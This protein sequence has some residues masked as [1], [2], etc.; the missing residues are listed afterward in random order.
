MKNKDDA[1]TPFSVIADF[2]GDIQALLNI[3]PGTLLPLLPVR[4][5][6]LFPSSLVPIA[7]ERDFSK[8]VVGQAQKDDRFI[9]LVYQKDS[10]VEHPSLDDLYPLGTIAR[11]MRILPGA[12]GRQTVFLQ[13]FNR[14]RLSGLMRQK[15]YYVGRIEQLKEI[16]PPADSQEFQAIAD[17]C[18][19]RIKKLLSLTQ[20]RES[21]AMFDTIQNPVF[22]INFICT[23]LPVDISERMELL[24]ESDVQLRALHLCELLGRELQYAEL[25]QKIEEEA[26]ADISEQQKEYF[27]RQQIFRMQEE[28][29]E[30]ALDDCDEL[31]QRAAEAQLPELQQKTFQKEVQKLRRLNPQSPDYNVQL[32]Y[33]QTIV[34]LPWARSTTDRL[35]IDRA[36]RILDHDHYGLEKIKQRII[37]ELAVFSLR[38]QASP[39]NKSNS[40]PI[41]RSPILCLYGPPGIGKTSLGRSIA[42]ALERRY[43]RMSLGGLHDEAEIRGHRRTYVGAM[44]G[45]ILQSLIK[46]G[47]NNPVFV[48]DEIDKVSQGNINGN[49]AAALLEALDPEQNSAF[50]DNYV[51]MDFNLSNVFF[52]CTANN[53]STIP[54]PLLDRMELIEMSGYITEE[55][56]QIARRHLIPKA[57]KEAGFLSSDRIIL[58]RN[59]LEAIIEN[60]TR[61]SGVRALEKQIQ[62]LMRKLAVEKVAGTLPHS[63]TLRPQELPTLLG[64]PPYSRS[65]YEGNA[66]AGVVTGL[67]WTQVGGE[68]LSVETSL[69]RGTDHKLTLTGNLGDVMKESALLALEYIKAHAD[70]LQI[71]ISVFDNW[72]IHV[73]VPEGAVPKD[74]PSAGITIATS[75]ASAL[76]QRKVRERTAMTGEITLRGDV[77]PVGGIKEKILAA[78]RAGITDIILSH[79]NRPN[80]EDIPAVY[81]D[82]LNFHYVHTVLEVLRLALLE[83][84][85][86]NPLTL[87]HLP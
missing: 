81:L 80:I 85:V 52:L 78:K 35:D 25:K 21:E 68:I 79:K 36:R 10:R 42:K 15:P 11:V 51:D 46:A 56:I 49:P 40:L 64:T 33:L 50:H 1:Q 70:D 8:T 84:Q 77:L 60:Y 87:T 86:D 44:P 22:L 2:D 19:S 26:R 47:S 5:M 17:T 48:L 27:L 34:N 54:A 43:V 29:G 6:L 58:P 28:L 45:R 14:F 67:A 62:T 3:E 4:G 61:E 82:Q 37:E 63:R 71:P 39:D 23:N 57:K 74:G 24:A 65:S 38:H 32:G 9:G 53:L 30:T 16:L 18:R 59:T 76:T 69:S 66:H 72:H 83:S 13:G 73:H 7:V 31:L 41:R 55:K 12:A 20:P 75:I